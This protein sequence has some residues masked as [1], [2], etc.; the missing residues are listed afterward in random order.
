MVLQVKTKL[1]LGG[2]FLKSGDFMGGQ[3]H[4]VGWTERV[5]FDHTIQL[6]AVKTVSLITMP[7][8]LS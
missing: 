8:Y 5:K 7:S 1:N 4:F 3:C 2:N 6:E